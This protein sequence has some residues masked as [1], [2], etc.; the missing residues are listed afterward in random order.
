MSQHQNKSPELLSQLLQGN[1][2]SV[3]D[4]ER[5]MQG[6][7]SG[8]NSP[9]QIAGMLVALQ[10]KAVV[11]DELDGFSSAVL[12]SAVDPQLPR[13]ALDIV[14]TGG[15]GLRTINVSTAAS[16]IAAA[17]GIPVIK[18]GNR[19]ASSASGASDVLS[20]L[21]IANSVSLETVR[22]AFKQ[23]GIA[24]L[25]APNMHP[26]F[27]HVA[28]VRRELGV[29]TVFNVLGPLC[30]P[31]QP[32]A[33]AL[34]VASEK[35]AELIAQ[36]LQRRPGVALVLRG[37]DGMDEL[38]VTDISKIWQVSQEQITEYVFDPRKVGIKFAGPKELQGG[39]PAENAETLKLIL[40]NE[41]RGPKRDIVALNAASGIVAFELSE[42][43]DLAKHDIHDRFVPALERVNAVVDSGDA[44]RALENWVSAISTR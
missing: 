44:A 34:G 26:G 42:N 13:R 33:I 19:A 17:A 12:R 24:Y 29:P 36:V 31:A 37:N 41:L 6:W 27:A 8:D 10:A 40:N 1:S 23:V 38:T 21:G 25:H 16:I 5:V 39:D 32:Q 2:L 14:G 11:A 18:H 20:A 4:A 7:I 35:N 9:A 28:P 22:T 15:D 30:N 43:P 3:S